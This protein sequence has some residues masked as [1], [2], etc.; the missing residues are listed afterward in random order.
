VKRIEGE[1]MSPRQR[2]TLL[3]AALA[4]TALLAAGCDRTPNT[5]SNGP[6]STAPDSNMS[7]RLG[8]PSSAPSLGTTPG[9]ST[10]SAGNASAPASDAA[11]TT[12]VK[13]AMMAEPGIRSA[14]IDVDTKDGVV[15]L[16]GSVDSQ[17]HK[18]RAIQLAQNVNGVKS[19]VD[20]LAVTG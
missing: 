6:S 17:Q 4:G 12:K 19:V 5:A 11:I 13:T 9:N 16:K 1:T 8:T 3:A 14:K 2:T 15:T 20:N 18:D 7:S 10:A